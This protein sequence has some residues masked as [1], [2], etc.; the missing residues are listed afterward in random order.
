MPRIIEL[1]DARN[2][3]LDEAASAIREVGFDPHDEESLH[4]T[5]GWLRR[6]G[7]NKTFLGDV[8]VE[9]L[10]QRHRE[11]VAGNA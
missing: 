1:E 3:A 10:A 7:N 8:L 4:H 6:L 9:Q 2:A 5:A 11:E